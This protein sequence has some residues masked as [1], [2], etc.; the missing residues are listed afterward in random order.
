MSALAWLV[1]RAGCTAQPEVP[2]ASD[3]VVARLTA[4]GPYTVGFHLDAVSWVPVGSDERTLRV[5]WWAPSQDTS[6]TPARYFHDAIEDSDALADATVADGRWPLLVFSHGHQG[7]AEASSFLMEHLASHGFVVVAPDHTGN[8]ALDGSDRDTEIYWQRPGDLSAVLDHAL[9]LPAEHPVGGHVGDFVGAMGHSFG[10][11]TVFAWGG[12]R[13]DS[14]ALDG[15]LSG[16]DASAFCSTYDLQDDALF[17]AGL[18]DPRVP[19]VAALAAGDQ[20]LVGSGL[21]SLTGP[22]LLG[23]GGLDSVDGAA[24]WAGLGQP[25]DRWFEVHR[26]GHHVFDDFAVALDPLDPPPIPADEG[27]A[28]VGGMVLAWALDRS[29]DGSAR[30]VLDGSVA[31]DVDEMSLTIP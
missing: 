25:D 6:G 20:D 28:I 13:F 10:G 24:W 11:Y 22:V 8:T 4:P 26:G 15:C 27:W 30:G 18:G 17:R 9:D 5:A 7:Y 31:L 21:Q 29:G 23:T 16:A 2:A 19:A 1:A 14:V 12:A 3:D